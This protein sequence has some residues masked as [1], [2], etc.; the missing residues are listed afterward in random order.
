MS[1]Q[2]EWKE[3]KPKKPK[4]PSKKT[5]AKKKTKKKPQKKEKVVGFYKENGETKPITAKS[6]KSVTHTRYVAKENYTGGYK[7]QLECEVDGVKYDIPV[8]WETEK[9]DPLVQS[10]YRTIKGDKI[11]NRKFVGPSKRMVY[12]DEDGEEVSKSEFHLVQVMPDGSTEPI[13]EFSKT[14]NINGKAYRKELMEEF[15]PHSYVEIWGD[16]TGSQNELRSL[17]FKLI[18]TGQIIAVQ[19]FSKSKGRKA[20]VG[21]IRAVTDDEGN[22]TLEMMVSENKRRRRRWMP[23]ERA[24]VGEEDEVAGKTAKVPKLFGD[25]Y[26]RRMR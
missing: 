16:S 14:K 19:Q 20:Y 12:V 10:E 5:T 17:A 21:F 7:A 22:F 6:G 25:S 11:V 3:F 13:D 23:S 15:H 4:K 18:K 8:R 9:V 24:I 1:R 2:I 26:R